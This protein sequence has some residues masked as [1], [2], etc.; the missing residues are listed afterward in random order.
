MLSLVFVTFSTL[1]GWSYYGERALEYL[2]GGRGI[3]IYRIMWVIVAY[4]GATTSLSIVWDFSDFAN[5]LMVIP[6]VICL[7]ALHKII[8][9]ETAKYFRQF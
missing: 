1:L 2:S 8:K 6:N 9:Q 7:V 3:M 4:I 5:A